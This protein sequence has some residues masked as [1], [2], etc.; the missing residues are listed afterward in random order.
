MSAHAFR[1]LLLA[2]LWAGATSSA[3][4]EVPLAALS[5]K[6]E[7]DQLARRGRHEAAIRAYL[8]AIA[9]AP[10]FGPAREGLGN[11]YFAVGNYELAAAQFREALRL[12]PSYVLGHYNLG[13]ALRKAGRLREAILHYETYL[14]TEKRP[15]EALWVQRARQ[16]LARLRQGSA[17]PVALAERPAV[18]ADPALRVKALE[19]ERLRAE[20]EAEARRHAAQEAEREAREAARR[21]AVEEEARRARAEEEARRIAEEEKRRL[22]AEAARRRDPAEVSRE[23]AA[24]AERRR[25]AQ[26]TAARRAAAEEE[27]R[28]IVSGTRGVALA[29]AR[30]MGAPETSRSDLRSG[31]GQSQPPRGVPASL[32]EVGPTT[33]RLLTEG[34]RAFHRREYDLAAAFYRQAAQSFPRWPAP[35]YKLGVAFLMLGDYPQAARAFGK[36]LELDP[37]HEGAR[38]NLTLTRKKLRN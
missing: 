14:A 26:E 23:A 35:V 1:L 13:Y 36:T 7:G 18:P 6:S 3:L 29:S 12:N 17:A 15:A 27:A 9:L 28:R 8:Q 33:L 4:A 30:P 32:G 19:V 31:P 38:R 16:E 22:E 20:A 37:Q 24:I 34:D 21:A 2:S 11:V 10:A 25:A 5:R